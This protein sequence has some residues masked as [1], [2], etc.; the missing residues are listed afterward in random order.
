MRFYTLAIISH[1]WPT[2]WA[3]IKS[4]NSKVEKLSA[5]LRPLRSMFKTEQRTSA[6][7]TA[8]QREDQCVSFTSL[9]LNKQHH[10]LSYHA[11]SNK[12]RDFCTPLW[13]CKKLAA[14]LL[15]AVSDAWCLPLRTNSSESKLKN[16]RSR[17]DSSLFFS[18]PAWTNHFDWVVWSG[19]GLNLVSHAHAASRRSQKTNIKE[20][21]TANKVLW[22]HRDTER[23]AVAEKSDPK[24]KED[25]R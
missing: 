12:Q 24:L 5:H 10:I 19:V 11:R 18:G 14:I 9:S 22:K 23:A 15:N 17:S 2:N 16:K 8:E 25:G 20:V 21:K 4:T 3:L 6:K 7:F 13:S 1:W